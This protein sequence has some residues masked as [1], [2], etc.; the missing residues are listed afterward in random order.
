MS[1]YQISKIYFTLIDNLTEDERKELEEAARPVW[2]TV[3]L[4]ELRYAGEHGYMMGN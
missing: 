1:E 2:D 3:L 4:R